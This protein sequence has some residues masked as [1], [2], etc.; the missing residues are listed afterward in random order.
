MKAILQV[1]G[2]QKI[3]E[4]PE[5]LPDIRIATLLPATMKVEECN[6]RDK[7]GNIIMSRF[8]RVG[9]QGAY[10]LYEYHGRW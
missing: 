9:N 2:W 10:V 6:V 3:I 4:I 8:R 7:D 5:P 1:D